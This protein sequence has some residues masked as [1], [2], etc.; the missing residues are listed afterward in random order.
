MVFALYEFK[1]VLVFMTMTTTKQGDIESDCYLLMMVTRAQ[2]IKCTIA[3]TCSTVEP[4]YNGDLGTMEITL[5]Y[6]G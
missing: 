6:Q 2:D 4:C 5:L 1:T 3:S